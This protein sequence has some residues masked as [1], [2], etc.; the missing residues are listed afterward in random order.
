MRDNSWSRDEISPPGVVTY[1]LSS[2][3]RQRLM[4][5]EDMSVAP[6][7]CIRLSSCLPRSSMK[8][9]L[10]KSINREDHLLGVSLQHLS[11]SST[12]APANFPSR[13]KRV[14]AGSL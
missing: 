8:L 2:S 13:T 3:M 14:S 4:M 1:D 11:S 6:L 7:S 9:T 12:Q 10:V 5:L